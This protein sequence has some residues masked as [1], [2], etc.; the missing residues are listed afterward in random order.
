MGYRPSLRAS[1]SGILSLYIL[2]PSDPNGA[3]PDTNYL[4]VLAKD[5]KF[6]TNSGDIFTLIDDVDFSNSNNEVVVGTEN[7]DTGKATSYVVKA[8][9]RVISGELKNELINVGSFV[10]FLTVPILDENITASS[11]S[12]RTSGCT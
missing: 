4:P 2:A 12:I 6:T 9:G 1:S 8:Y 10:R 11:F 7:S 3:G 5:T